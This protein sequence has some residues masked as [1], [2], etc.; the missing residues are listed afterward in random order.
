MVQVWRI[1]PAALS[2]LHALR[3]TALGWKKTP[4]DAGQRELSL[5]L[6]LAGCEKPGLQHRT[7][8]TLLRFTDPGKY[9]PIVRNLDLA[10]T[11]PHDE[12]K[13]RFPACA[14]G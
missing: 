5:G 14:H 7:V 13:Q 11:M 9:I 2:R 3:T 4:D 12:L 1:D 10:E 6:E 8:T